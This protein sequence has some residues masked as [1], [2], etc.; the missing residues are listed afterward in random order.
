MAGVAFAVGGDG[1]GFTT[2]S[3]AV[4]ALYPSG[5]LLRIRR[6]SF[7]CQ[8]LGALGVGISETSLKA[9]LGEPHRKLPQP[10][11]A[12]AYVYFLGKTGEFPYLAAIVKANRT[13][14]L[15]ISGEAPVAAYSFNRVNLGDST[16][17]LMAQFGGPFHVGPSGLEK[18]E[19]WTYEPW[20]FSFEVRQ[21]RVTSIRI[22][23]PTSK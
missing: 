10:N 20:P 22:S 7:A 1:V 14:A 23:D 8:R 11:N 2:E 21:D 15:Q 3:Y 6:V 12:T 4:S 18:T 16:D 13:V 5:A 9:V 19:L 17:K